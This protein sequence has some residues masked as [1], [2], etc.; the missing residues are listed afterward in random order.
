MQTDLVFSAAR[1]FSKIVNNPG[2]II[3]KTKYILL[4][5]CTL[6]TSP[7]ISVFIKTLQKKKKCSVIKLGCMLV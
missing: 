4:A 5:I 6:V 1:D 7:Q 2:E 3:Y